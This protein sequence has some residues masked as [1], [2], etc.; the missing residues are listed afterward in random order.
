MTRSDRCWTC[1]RPRGL[2]QLRASWHLRM[3]LV[4]IPRTD[5]PDDRPAQ[6]LN[7]LI[8]SVSIFRNGGTSESTHLCD[9]C[10]RVGVRAIKV[11]LDELLGEIDPDHYAEKTIADLTDR[12]ALEQHRRHQAALQ[13]DR[14][15]T[16]LRDILPP[17]RDDEPEELRMARWEVERGPIA[18]RGAA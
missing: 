17:P 4:M 16:R 2:A 13:H 10:L 5:N 6:T 1:G 14:M 3:P 9:D 11:R 8:C 12:L 15:L 7:D 18:K